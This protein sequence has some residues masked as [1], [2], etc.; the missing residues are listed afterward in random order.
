VKAAIWAYAQAVGRIAMNPVFLGL[1]EVIAI[2][3]DQ[4]YPEYG[5]GCFSG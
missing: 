1:G 4:Y 2:H 5:E 3:K